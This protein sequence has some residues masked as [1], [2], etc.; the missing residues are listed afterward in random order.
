MAVY[1]TTAEIKAKEV[2]VV[3]KPKRIS[4]LDNLR[5]LDIFGKGGES[6][7]RFPNMIKIEPPKKIP[8]PCTEVSGATTEVK[9]VEVKN[10]FTPQMNTIRIQNLPNSAIKLGNNIITGENLALR[11][12]PMSD[13]CLNGTI[14]TANNVKLL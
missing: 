9:L 7:E 4:L 3:V 14:L 5:G 13:I 12:I 6:L 8:A 11:F 1:R 2:E 10:K